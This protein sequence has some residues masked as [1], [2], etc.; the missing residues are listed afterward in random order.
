MSCTS[1]ILHLA[2]PYMHT[3]LM[4]VPH[5]YSAVSVLQA[6]AKTNSIKLLVSRSP[7][8]RDEFRRLSNSI[9]LQPIPS[10]AGKGKC[11]TQCVY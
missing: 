7:N 5:I 11:W 1:V 6:C 3:L 9:L 8:S 2:I 10:V 4:S